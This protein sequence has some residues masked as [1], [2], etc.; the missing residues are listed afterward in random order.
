MNDHRYI[1]LDKEIPYITPSPSMKFPYKIQF[2]KE[3][4]NNYGET[5][6]AGIYE[7]HANGDVYYEN[8]E[9]E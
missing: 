3:W 7:F 8:T 2:L 5:M 4:I 9:D 1:K 6:E